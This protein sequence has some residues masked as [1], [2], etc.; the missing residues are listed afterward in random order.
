MKCP[1]CNEPL[2]QPQG[3]GRTRQY[4][5]ERC[6]LIAWRR[7]RLESAEGDLERWGP[8]VDLDEMPLPPVTDPQNDLAEVLGTLLYTKG[9]L[10]SIAPRIQANLAWRCREMASHIDAGLTAYFKP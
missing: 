2:H 5:S 9:R 8:E 6:R 1:V 3:K 4:C 7:R 10:L